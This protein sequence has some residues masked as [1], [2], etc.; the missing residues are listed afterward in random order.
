MIQ[1]IFGRR[2]TFEVSKQKLDSIVIAATVLVKE[3]HEAVDGRRIT[4]EDDSERKRS[5]DR[6]I[7]IVESFVEIPI[8]LWMKIP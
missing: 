3:Q 8:E 6:Y 4:R 2:R 1:S 5:E 7:D